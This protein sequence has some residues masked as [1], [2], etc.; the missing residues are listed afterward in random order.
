MSCCP[1]VAIPVGV[2]EGFD[3]THA[4]SSVGELDAITSQYFVFPAS[5]IADSGVN[6]KSPYVPLDDDVGAT[7]APYTDALGALLPSSSRIE[8]SATSPSVTV[9]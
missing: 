8:S 7:S 3:R 9:S 5:V 4:K 1:A 6:T 2:T